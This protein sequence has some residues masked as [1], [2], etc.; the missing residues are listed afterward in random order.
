MFKKISSILGMFL[1]N[2]YKKMIMKSIQGS[3]FSSI[4]TPSLNQQGCPAD[5]PG[6]KNTV[7]SLC[8]LSSSAALFTSYNLSINEHIG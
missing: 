4:I 2:H 1:S 7:F 6:V 5:G 8:G 3:V